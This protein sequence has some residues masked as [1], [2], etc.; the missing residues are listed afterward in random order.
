MPELETMEQ[1]RG[2]I[3]RRRRLFRMGSLAAMMCLFLI[4]ANP[5]WALQLAPSSL[6]FSAT[7][8]GT[9]P[10]AQNV[11]LTS[12]R[13]RER[14]W[15]ATSN[16]SWLTLTPASGTITTEQDTVTVKATAAGLATGSYSA[17]ITITE[18]SLSG[19]IRRNYLPVS[20]S[21]TGAA[22][23]PALQLSPSA[24]NFTGAA[25]GSNPPSQTFS[26]STSG[27]TSLTWTATDNAAWLSLSPSS[28]T[29]SGMVT[30]AVNLSGLA[31][32]TYSA[33]I[34]ASAPGATSKT[35]PV[36]LT[37]SSSSTTASIWSSP[38]PPSF[39]AMTGGPAP[40]AQTMTLNSTGGPLSWTASD[41]APWLTLSPASGS[42]PGNLVL[43]VNP[44]S[45]AA[46]TYNGLITV[47]APSANNS[48]HYIPVTLTVTTPTGTPVIGLSPT[49]L[50]FSGTA[51]GANPTAQSLSVTNA[52]TGTL[53]WT[54]TDNAAWLTLAPGSGTNAGSVTASVNTAGLA[55]GTYTAA[56]TLSATGAATKTVPVTLTVTA[57]T[58]AP[59]IGVAPVS[60]SFSGTAGGANPTA[61]SFSI[62]N[63]GTGTLS[64]SATDNAAWLN[65]TPASGTNAGTV[66]ASVNTAG[67]AAGTY[68]AVVTISAT[69]ATAKTV[70]VTLT[71][72]SGSSGVSLW[73]SPAPPSFSGTVGGPAP[74]T[75][76]LTINSTG[77]LLS[78][79]ATDNAT[80]LS[81]SPS[82]GSTPGNLT[83]TV[84]PVGLAAGTYNGLITVTAPSANNSPHYV[85]VTLTLTAT[86]STP[87]I[88]FSPASLNF[89]GMAGG[90]NPTAQSLSI[91]NI[92]T[93]TLTWSV[94]D[95]TAWLG[96]T[97][98]S[99]TNAGSVSAS[100]NTAG[101][102]A[103]TY[104]ATITISATGATS[105]TVPVTL[106]VTASGTGSATL[107]WNANTETDLAGYKVYF[108]TQSGVYG[109]PVTLG[110][111]TS[112][113]VTN[114]AKGNTYFFTV[115]AVDNAGNESKPAPELS[116]SIF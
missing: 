10:A 48:P 4:A 88:G 33:V 77:G 12:S 114:L 56:I 87:A 72:S 94:T 13:T 78:W 39:T 36:T 15:V 62:T 14:S 9:D 70:P 59:V 52:G 95:N 107:T 96:L 86:T 47:T 98:A 17:T 104:N 5:A 3:S 64:W 35:L 11:T 23:I 76:T 68:S 2:A 53:T 7:A 89:S 22:S 108:G 43:T 38:G 102:T 46:G 40:A 20:F 57:P 16:V 19:R 105:K 92:G 111:V 34:T 112:Y 41:N 79:T 75:Q 8:G 97:P 31:A 32:G 61:Q 80:W 18:T 71:V 51:G 83:M 27:S 74:A 81:L 106:T 42:T 85:P 55:A 109:A 1:E 50:N 90:A 100:V 66:T 45:L 24:L 67:L 101:L 54:A 115:T 28:G 6:S 26:V 29:N 60:L 93:G 84:N 91:T 69:G 58:S 103:G 116:K 99:G 25:G 110:K 63:T 73:S 49:N 44:T 65:L 113:T 37:V 82:S 21:V 30:A